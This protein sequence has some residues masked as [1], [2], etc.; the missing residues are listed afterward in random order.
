LLKILVAV[1][2]ACSTSYKAPLYDTP[3]GHL[4]QGYFVGDVS[5]WT[6]GMMSTHTMGWGYWTICH[7]ARGNEHE[8]AL[9]KQEYEAL[10]IRGTPQRSVMESPADAALDA[11]PSADQ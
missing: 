2:L 10:M 6:T 7:D 11:F 4:D 3:S 8:F 9:T 5:A 1:E